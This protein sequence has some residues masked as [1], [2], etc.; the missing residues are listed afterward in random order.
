MG[1]AVCQMPGVKIRQCI[2]N[3][4][5]LLHA[6]KYCHLVMVYSF[7]LNIIFIEKRTIY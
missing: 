7:Y 1:V 6:E 5:L 2:T 3:T 4:E